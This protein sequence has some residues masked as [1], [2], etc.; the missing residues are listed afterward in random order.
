[1]LG[2]RN[3]G[4]SFAHQAKHSHI[5]TFFN[6][7]GNPDS[8]L[9]QHTKVLPEFPDPGPLKKSGTVGESRLTP[10]QPDPCPLF[11]VKVC[12]VRVR[13]HA[14]RLPERRTSWRLGVE[15]V[16]SANARKKQTFQTV[17]TG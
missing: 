5:T 6:G 13:T 2:Q 10:L 1:M 9:Q 8:W 15:G 11:A 16:V 17:F 4:E 7:I 14:E 12:P 3:I